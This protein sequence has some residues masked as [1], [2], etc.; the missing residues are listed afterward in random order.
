VDDTPRHLVGHLHSSL[1]LLLLILHQGLIPY[2]LPIVDRLCIIQ[3][4]ESFR[5]LTKLQVEVLVQLEMTVEIGHVLLMVRLQQTAQ[6]WRANVVADEVGVHQHSGIVDIFQ[7]V[8]ETFVS[9]IVIR[10]FF[11]KRDSN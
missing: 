5:T 3:D 10:N 6:D 2:N 4:V 1:A 11:I 8:H 9:F 7:C